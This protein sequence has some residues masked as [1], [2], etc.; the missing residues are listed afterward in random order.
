MNDAFKHLYCKCNDFICNICTQQKEDSHSFSLFDS[1][2]H[3][4]KK[5]SNHFYPSADPLSQL[6]RKGFISFFQIAFILKKLLGFL[7]AAY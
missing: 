2:W 6:K 5:G 7:L 1:T 3:G 4:A